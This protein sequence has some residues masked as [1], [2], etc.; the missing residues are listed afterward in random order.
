MEPSKLTRNQLLN[1]K[2]FKT[3]E[4][5]SV[6][7]TRSL[8]GYI[9]QR[10]VETS[11][12]TV[13]DVVTTIGVI[14]FVDPKTDQFF[15]MFV[16]S[17][18]NL[19]PSNM[20]EESV[21]GERYLTMEFEEGDLVF[22]SLSSIQDPNL[23]YF[24]YRE[25]SWLS[26]LPWYVEGKK[27]RSMFDQAGLITGRSVGSSPAVFRV[28]TSLNERDPDDPTKPYRYSKAILEGRPPLM[29]GLNN[30]SLLI[31]GTFNRL[32]G[33]YDQDNLIMAVLDKDTRVTSEEL[34]IKGGFADE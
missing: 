13:T 16:Q 14:G 27:V 26:K 9:P 11:L 2:A 15:S 28:M 22:R 19:S 17:K 33:G 23:N 20:G 10:F 34:I 29:V 18:F 32:I 21:N 6:V 5:G 31:D 3:L 25:F 30:G 8:I 1:R 24:F 7:A 12:A 4:D